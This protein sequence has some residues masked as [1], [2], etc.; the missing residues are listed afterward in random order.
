MAAYRKFL[1]A[2]GSSPSNYFT[3]STTRNRLLTCQPCMTYGSRAIEKKLGIP[4][5]PKRPMTPFIAYSVLERGRIVKEHPDLRPRDIMKKIAEDW[6][7]YSLPH[8]EELRKNYLHELQ[9]YTKQIMA[10]EEKLTDEQKKSIKDEKLRGMEATEKVKM[11]AKLRELGK[12]KKPPTMFILFMLSRAHT[13]EKDMKFSD[14]LSIA[15]KEWSD[16]PREVKVKF[17]NETQKLMEQYKKEMINWEEKMI[18][19]GHIDVVR[20][21]VLMDLK[22]KNIANKK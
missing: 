6:K 14:W 16:A 20:K 21:Q 5:R 19:L 8:K 10:Y 1:T 12:P 9:E 17:E 11:K 15:A 13:K 18:K 7:T 4:P 22:G 3:C 2:F